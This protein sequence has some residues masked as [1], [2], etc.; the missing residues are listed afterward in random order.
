M[1]AVPAPVLEFP[2]R[3]QWLVWNPPA[4]PRY[5]FDILAVESGRLFRGSPWRYVRGE[6]TAADSVGW[7]R[8]VLAAAAGV[9]V[10]AVDGVADRKSLNPWVD[11]PGVAMRGVVLP[12]RDV[13]SLAGNHVTIRCDA[14]EVLLAHLRCG[15][16][17]VRPGQQVDAGTL[18]GEV[19][20]SGN[21]VA[22]HLHFQLSGAGGRLPWPRVLPFRVAEYERWNAGTWER[23]A[24]APLPRLARV[25][26]RAHLP[27]I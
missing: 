8:P 26:V 16:V 14:G 9:V 17:R 20:N 22:P 15:S 24:D 27:P 3:G 7:S 2:L 11:L 5:A 19:G 23:V 6:M 25:R 1:P 18:V 13:V 12:G 10:A 21:T 4:H